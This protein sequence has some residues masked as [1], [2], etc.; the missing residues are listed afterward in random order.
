MSL[1]DDP[2]NTT[3]ITTISEEGK[4]NGVRPLWMIIQI[5]L[6]I[7]AF[8]WL[9]KWGGISFDQVID[10]AKHIS[11][12]PILIGILLF[13]FAALLN[14]LR[15]SL[16]FGNTINLRYLTGLYLFQNTLITFIPWRLG[17]LSYPIL[18]YKDH[19]V[20][21]SKSLAVLLL[22]RLTDFSI[23]FFIL[24]IS[25]YRVSIRLE[26]M[27]IFFGIVVVAI[28]SLIILN[29]WVKKSF[30][31]KLFQ[32]LK[33]TIKLILNTQTITLLF[34]FSVIL[35]AVMALQTKLILEAVSLRMGYI[36]VLVFNAISFIAALL[37]IHPPGGWGTMDS[38]QLF[39]IGNMG[40]DPRTSISS[41]LVAHTIYSVIILVGGAIGWLLRKN[42]WKN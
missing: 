10:R 9:F 2:I 22:I 12:L 24:L 35:I 42:I 27:S 7:F 38:I 6:G 33:F 4:K 31:Q 26:W 16:F 17:E 40:Y 29:K 19:G 15:Y 1:V 25:G 14:A 20:P 3:L 30:L 21:A 37:P 36:Q 23:I 13:S 11:L 32:S 41:I 18:L 5:A 8:I 28:F 34:V 39:V